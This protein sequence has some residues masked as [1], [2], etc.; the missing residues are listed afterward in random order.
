MKDRNYKKEEKIKH[1][2]VVS[3]K[4][5]VSQ[6]IYLALIKIN[7]NEKEEVQKAYWLTIKFP[8]EISFYGTE[9]QNKFP[10]VH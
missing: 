7:M 1:R 6:N 3:I 2:L 8:E 4:N 9:S 10:I 5:Y